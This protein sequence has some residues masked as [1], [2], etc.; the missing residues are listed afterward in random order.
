MAGQ[1][2]WPGNGFGQPMAEVRSMVAHLTEG[3]PRRETV[4]TFINRYTVPGTAKRGIGPQFQVTGDGTV[5]RLIDMPRIT[6]HASFVNGWSIGVETNNLGTVGRPPNRNWEP[7]SAEAEDIPGAKLWITSRRNA[8]TEVSPAWWT[9]AA[10]AGPARGAVGAGHMLFGEDVYRSWALLA[11]WLMEEHRLPRNF[12]LLPHATRPGVMRA[13]APFR[14][15]VL[16]D[17]RADMMIRAFSA[18]PVNITPA[19]FNAGNEA[20]LQTQ[21]NAAV[22]GAGG[23]LLE[24]NR[25]W[26]KLF[27][28]YRGL[29]GH[30]FPGRLLVTHHDHDCP[31]PLFDFHRL[32]RE[33]WDWWWYPFDFDAPSA[34]TA[35]PRRGYRKF[36]ADSPLIEY[37]FDENEAVRTA[38]VAA[39]IH[40]NRASP[41]TFSLDAASPIYALANGTLVA[42]RF[43]PERAGVSLAFVLVRHEVFHRPLFPPLVVFGTPVP[44]GPEAI[45]YGRAPS[46]VYT[47][48][49]HLG[50]PAGMSLD[51]V[52]EDNPDWLNRVLIRKKECELGVAFYDDDPNHHGIAPAVWNNRPPGVPQRPTTLEGWRADDAA[53]GGFL[54]ALRAGGPAV[55]FGQPFTQPIRILL[56]DFLGESGVIR[57]SGATVTRGVRVEAFSPTFVPPTF[58]LVTGQTGW[59]PPA[60]RPRPCLPYVSEWARAPSAAEAQAMT[61]IGVDTAQLGWWQAVSLVQHLD[62]SVPRDARLPFAGP[63]FHYQPIDFARWINDVTWKSE[64]PKYKVVDAANVPVGRPARPQT[65]RV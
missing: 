30:F 21:Y 38:R 61:A 12:P 22:A 26:R 7:A 34:T 16:A 10:Y 29:H 64:W 37:F 51:D 15:I 28:V 35:A 17:Q 59:N 42:A 13:S 3:W 48:Y 8:H 54:D 41:T 24:H 65:R 39:G 31:G 18:A 25:A 53:L 60:G 36:T 32:A 52:R 43:P 55:T 11:R 23:G 47:L 56:G 63:V 49:M 5:F 50:R 62:P 1:A 58:S 14:R 9:T 20:A 6:K 46:A 2:N 19:N 4:S 57:R 33:V 27:D 44:M 40:G 45:D